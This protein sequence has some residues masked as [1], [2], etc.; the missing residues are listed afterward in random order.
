MKPVVPASPSSVSI[1]AGADLGDG[2]I[3][4]SPYHAKRKAKRMPRGGDGNFT[5]TSGA[6][7]GGGSDDSAGTP[8][9]GGIRFAPIKTTSPPPSAE[10]PQVAGRPPSHF[11]IA[12]PRTQ[13]NATT[14]QQASPEVDAA[15]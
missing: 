1:D 12:S 4:P 15:G 10:S 14:K 8:T 11:A 9:I 2:V 13:A 6:G 7:G 3:S 5:T